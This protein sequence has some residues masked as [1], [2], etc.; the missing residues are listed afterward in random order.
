MT[1]Q[2][3]NMIS[4]ENDV[5]NKINHQEYVVSSV[6]KEYKDAEFTHKSNI[7][8][9]IVP[10]FYMNEKLGIVVLL[11]KQNIQLLLK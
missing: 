5:I 1:E 4:F 2:E 9:V 7:T 11:I 3:A 8:R 6:L 10:V